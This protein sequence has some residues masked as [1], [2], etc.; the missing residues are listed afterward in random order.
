[1]FNGRIDLAL[2]GYNSGENRAEYRAAASQGR[3]INWS[4]MPAGVR[5]ETQ[6]YV[7][8]IMRNAGANNYAAIG[9]A[10]LSGGSSLLGGW[11]MAAVGAAVLVV[12]VL[13]TD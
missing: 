7:N 11:S 6:N 3:P 2:A 13:A 10:N 8:V 12:V 1:M 9:S 4:V 5:S